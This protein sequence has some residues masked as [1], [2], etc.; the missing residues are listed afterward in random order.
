MKSFLEHVVTVE[1]ETGPEAQEV[2]SGFDQLRGQIQNMFGIL[3]KAAQNT[4]GKGTP[5]VAERLKQEI[6]ADLIGII[7]KLKGPQLQNAC[8]RIAG[9]I[10][11]MLTEAGEPESARSLVSGLRPTRTNAETGRAIYDMG[12]VLQ[13]I[14][15]R[16]MQ[17]VGQLEKSVLMSKLGDIQ[18]DLGRHAGDIRGDVDRLG[19]GVGRGL[20][21][22]H[23]SLS[24]RIDRAAGD[25]RGDIDYLGRDVAGLGKK[26]DAGVSD[27]RGDVA[28]YGQ[29]HGAALDRIEKGKGGRFDAEKNA[30]LLGRLSDIEKK[31]DRPPQPL[32]DKQQDQAYQGIDVLQKVAG[33]GR[34]HGM[35]LVHVQTSREIP[36]D[37]LGKASGRGSIL[38]LASRDRRFKL[39]WDGGEAEFNLG[40]IQDVQH[41]ADAFYDDKHIDPNHLPNRWKTKAFGT[42][43]A[44]KLRPIKVKD[45]PPEMQRK[46]ESVDWQEYMRKLSGLE[47]Q[48]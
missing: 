16:I 48:E 30:E 11:N 29:S 34:D 10:E 26:V 37:A 31:M 23:A 24:D 45:L 36:L 8:Y 2:K 17:S 38:S 44:G 39:V 22:T 47:K 33:H 1:S 4:W 41:A 40:N 43:H 13:R 18:G 6:I 5:G 21:R 9:D 28:G 46:E 3:H 35:R 7:Q 25:V 20:A 27:I 32:T 15:D 42:V 14:E 19:R 12:D